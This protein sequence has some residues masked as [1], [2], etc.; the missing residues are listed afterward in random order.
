MTVNRAH[1]NLPG[2]ICPEQQACYSSR[3]VA[4]EPE[5][6]GDFQTDDRTSVQQTICPTVRRH[7]S[8]V[9]HRQP[10]TDAPE[11]CLGSKAGHIP[12]PL[13]ISGSPPLR[14]Q[15][16][17]CRAGGTK[18]NIPSLRGK[19]Q[20]ATVSYHR[21]RLRDDHPSDCTC[22]DCDQRVV[23]NQRRQWRVPSGTRHPAT[24]T[25]TACGECQRLAGVGEAGYPPTVAE[26][27]PRG[28]RKSF[29]FP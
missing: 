19:V 25:C 4:R 18:T 8:Q 23:C 14:R 20:G 1:W 15:T 21:R 26:R 7:N 13:S 9:E 12:R 2:R 11:P 6:S 5:R 17:V 10:E 24:G 22:V 27:P 28:Q 16:P 3:C 29:N